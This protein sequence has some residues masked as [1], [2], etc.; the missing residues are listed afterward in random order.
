LK[1]AAV[2]RYGSYAIGNATE[3]FLGDHFDVGT[4]A[5]INRGGAVLYGDTPSAVA[6]L[7]WSLGLGQ[8]FGRSVSVS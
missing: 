6:A 5:T 7:N 4:Y 2:A 3:R 8:P 1:S